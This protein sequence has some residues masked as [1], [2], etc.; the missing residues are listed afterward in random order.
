MASRVPMRIWLLIGRGLGNYRL[1]SVA[2]LIVFITLYLI[3]K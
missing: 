1:A 2:V 3:F